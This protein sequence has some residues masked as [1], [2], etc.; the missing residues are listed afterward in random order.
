MIFLRVVGLIVGVLL[1]LVGG[2]C[3]FFFLGN[4]GTIGAGTGG[5]F[6]IAF[7]ALG[8]GIAI[9]VSSVRAMR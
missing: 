1:T 7:L 4:P 6:M 9:V 2:G 5:I 3:T 8:V